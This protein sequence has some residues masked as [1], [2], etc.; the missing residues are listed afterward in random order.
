MRG[1]ETPRIALHFV[2]TNKNLHTLSDMVRLGHSLGAFRIDFDA[3]IAYT[4]EQLALQLSDT[5]RQQIP[6][7]AAEAL[8]LAN[9]LG[10]ATTLENFLNPENLDRG[11]TQITAPEAPGLKGAPCLKAWHY[12]VIQ[13]DG[14]SSPCCVLAGEGGS[15][16]DV[17]LQSVWQTDP[18]M[19]QVRS[20][21]LNKQP[22]PRC[23]ECS[24]NILRH[25]AEIRRH[26]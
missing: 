7:I 9:E 3:L 13:A 21:M 11:N 20:G 24:W 26:L 22:L 18:F 2:L 6:S 16:A 1:L 8:A 23:Q 4:D 17:P 19:E 5:Q 25:E 10:I 15:A 12:L 14:R